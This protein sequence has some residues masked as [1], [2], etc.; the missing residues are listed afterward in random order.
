[1][2]V[3]YANVLMIP[4]VVCLTTAVDDLCVLCIVRVA[5]RRDMMDAQYVHAK[6]PHLATSTHLH[7][8]GVVSTPNVAVNSASLDLRRIRG[9]VI[10]AAANLN[11]LMLIPLKKTS[12]ISNP[13]DMRCAPFP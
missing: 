10:S 5:L 1:M 8:E 6:F 2:A 4:T 9:D 7:P 3:T 12:M 13:C 11:R